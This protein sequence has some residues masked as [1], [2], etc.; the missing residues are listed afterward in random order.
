M[1]QLTVQRLI[2][3]CASRVAGDFHCANGRCIPKRW[4]CD[5]DDDC[6]DG[7][8]EATT[9]CAAVYRRCSESEFR[10]DN[11]KCIPGRWRCDHDNDC[12][13]G[14]DEEG[15]GENMSHGTV[16]N[17]LIDA[18]LLLRFEVHVLVC[19]RDVCCFIARCV[20]ML[21]HSVPWLPVG[22]VPLRQRSLRQ[23]AL[24]V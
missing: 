14:S 3:L 10:C 12:G 21:I 15:C 18:K 17:S 6:G 4:Q 11:H 19:N 9:M 13:D 20:F 7:S 16:R 24:R 1:Y 22:S 5:F 8:D 23:R 2:V